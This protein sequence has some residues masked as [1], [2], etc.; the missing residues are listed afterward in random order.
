VVR[1]DLQQLLLPYGQQ[2]QLLCT[3]V[4]FRL[5]SHALSKDLFRLH[6]HLR[7]RLL[8]FSIER[9][10]TAFQ[11]MTLQLLVLTAASHQEIH[12]MISS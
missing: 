5:Q 7:L 2:M 6:L 1:K 4:T 9:E 3:I 8:S 12:D 10:G 11:L